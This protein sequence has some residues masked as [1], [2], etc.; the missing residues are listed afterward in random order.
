MGPERKFINRVHRCVDT[1]VYKECTTGMGGGVPDYYYEGF[2]TQLRIEYK[3]FPGP[4]PKVIE[5]C[6]P[7]SKVGLSALQRRWLNRHIDNGHDAWVVIGSDSGGIILEN[8][9]W[10]DAWLPGEDTSVYVPAS[11]AKRI[12]IFIGGGRETNCGYA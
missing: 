5:I 9:E 12:E 7:K 2:Q 4:L 6:V 1:T 3:A 11:I 8:G 10:E